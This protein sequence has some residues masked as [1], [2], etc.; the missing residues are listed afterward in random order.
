MAVLRQA[1]LLGDQRIDVPHLRAIES[2]TAA[3]FDVVA[4]R[5]QAGGKA[6]VIRGFALSNYAAG[7]A[8]SSIQLN[9]AD[10]VLYNQNATEAGTFLWVPLDRPV[11][12]LD[13]A[14]NARVD[15]SFVAGTVNYIGVDLTRQTDAT[16]TDH[17]KFLDANTLLEQG[18]EVPLARTLDYRIVITSTPFSALP[19]LTPIAKVTSDANNQVVAVEDARNIMWRLGSGGDF[20]NSTNGYAWPQDRV[21]VA[22][23]FT[24]GDKGILSQKDWQDAV[25]SRV[26]ELGGGEN[27]YSPTADR[28]FKLVGSPTAI[29]ISTGDNFEWLTGL[30]GVSHLHWQGLRFLFENSNTPGIYYNTITDQLVD[31]PAG[32]AATSKTA[33]APGECLYVDLD[34]TTNATLTAQKATMQN[35]GEPVVPG[36][37][38]I[39]VWRNADGWF[40]RDGNFAAHVLPPSSAATITDIGTVRLAYAAGTPTTPTVSPLN[41]N[42]A[43]RIGEGSYPVTAGATALYGYSASGRGVLGESVTG[44]GVE[45]LS[46][47]FWG[48]HFQGASGATITGTNGVGVEAVGGAGEPGA[49][50]TGVTGLFGV[51]IAWTGGGLFGAGVSGASD[52][53]VGVRGVSRDTYGVH[54]TGSTGGVYGTSAAYGIE[55][56]CVGGTNNIA[57]YGHS[58]DTGSQGVVGCGMS[59]G[60][61]GGP[62]TTGN[63]PVTGTYGEGSSS[64]IEGVSANTAVYGHGGTIGCYGSGTSYGVE[65]SSSN[66]SGVGVRGVNS[67]TATTGS[68]WAIWGEAIAG[69]GT[70]LG[71]GVG[72]NGRTCGVY[73][74]SP[75]G[76]G[77]RGQGTGTTSGGVVGWHSSDAG[78]TP[79][80]AGVQGYGG[81]SYLGGF[82]QG[83]IGGV[84]AVCLGGGYAVVTSSG[85]AN[86]IN[87]DGHIAMS[88]ANTGT[89]T[90]ITNKVVPDNQV[91]AYGLV[92]IDA[93]GVVTV[94][95]GFNVGAISPLPTPA[96]RCQVDLLGNMA[97]ELSVIS[98][99]W[100]SLDSWVTPPTIYG[101]V[102]AGSSGATLDIFARDQ[103]TGNLIDWHDGVARS[104]TFTVHGRQ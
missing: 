34:R 74:T 20:P 64:G 15:G 78:F 42:N 29:F 28:N 41:A 98:V 87:C 103:A 100:S 104:F 54:G 17:V 89:S 93:P 40:R 94:T 96:G 5:V 76:D 38:V 68:I 91:K 46:P 102:T 99:Q 92:G 2:A 22:G 21:E 36:S 53:L 61:Y 26:W 24:G 101:R 75:D 14:L 88:G 8:T 43:I 6:L 33:L 47:S 81:S 56:V 86:A 18:Y 85:G 16:T 80:A 3:D 77:V 44:Y 13:S 35:L 12:V 27:W 25:M 19:H 39:I 70:S 62:G 69:A 32:S 66:A 83:A 55:G 30:Y 45:G 79:E 63:M 7:I 58:S 10:G 84:K 65:G 23:A 1:N 97:D 57:V 50:G 71:Y 49:R 31:D 52:T 72:G 82:F 48:A 67:S 9:T 73:G 51:G 95:G 90:A 4:G 59:R 60:V 11:E 37:R